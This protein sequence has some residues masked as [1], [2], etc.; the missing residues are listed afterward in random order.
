VTISDDSHGCGDTERGAW[1]RVS[2]RAIQRPRSVARWR[3]VAFL[4]I[5]VAAVVACSTA[6]SDGPVTIKTGAAGGAC[7]LASVGGVLIADQTDGLAFKGQDRN[8][9]VVFPYGYSA[10]REAG[11]ILLIDPSGRVIAREGDQIRGAGA[12]GDDIT[13][14]MCD[15]I[16]VPAPTLGE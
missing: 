10:R 4:V 5:A 9:R 1:R 6:P 8:R 13:F 7:A 2:E 3:V 16:V 14:L 11:V 15:L 12:L